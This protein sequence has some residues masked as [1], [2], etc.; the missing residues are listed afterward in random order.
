MFPCVFTSV[1]HPLLYILSVS[2]PVCC[3]VLPYCSCSFRLSDTLGCSQSVV[4][5]L[6]HSGFAFVF[7]AFF[8]SCDFKFLSLCWVLPSGSTPCLPLSPHNMTL[9]L[10]FVCN[11]LRLQVT[12]ACFY[13]YC[14]YASEEDRKGG[15]ENRRN[16]IQELVWIRH[17]GLCSGLD[18]WLTY[19]TKWTKPSDKLRP[20]ALIYGIRNQ[21]LIVI[22]AYWLKALTALQEHLAAQ[23]E[24]LLT[25]GTHPNWLT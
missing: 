19:S 9:F 21:D 1:N 24:G 2:L 3:C 4:S 11:K 20:L 15:R 10:Y 7:I 8:V 13:L 6:V 16:Y 23:I 25:T 14:Y 12:F 17:K 5:Q 22:H 18:I